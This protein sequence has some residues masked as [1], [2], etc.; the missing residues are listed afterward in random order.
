MLTWFFLSGCSTNDDDDWSNPRGLYKTGDPLDERKLMSYY[1]ATEEDAA[2]AFGYV[3]GGRTD[4]EYGTQIIRD[5]STGYYSLGALCLGKEV[6]KLRSG[7]LPSVYIPKVAGQTAS[8]HTHTNST[9]GHPFSNDDVNMDRNDH[10][11]GYVIHDNRKVY[12]STYESVS[13]SMKGKDGKGSA[14]EPEDTYL[15]ETAN[16]YNGEYHFKK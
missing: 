13:N 3:Y 14:Y 4:R 15:G 2:F 12:K 16:W 8:V 1:Y 7:E 11:N 5:S 10:V 6:A 9:T